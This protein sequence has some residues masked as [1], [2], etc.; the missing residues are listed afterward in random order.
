MATMAE[1]RVV[2]EKAE[3]QEWASAETV[4][5]VVAAL[6]VVRVVDVVA[7]APRVDS[8]LAC[9]LRS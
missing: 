9:H 5:V 3:V 8:L 4:E 2:A 1:E 6:R 7:V